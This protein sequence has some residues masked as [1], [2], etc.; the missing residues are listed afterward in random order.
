MAT[1]GVEIIYFLFFCKKDVS[2]TKYSIPLKGEF[3]KTG[4]EQ[5]CFRSI[6]LVVK[7]PRRMKMSMISLDCRPVVK[8]NN[9]N[10]ITGSQALFILAVASYFTN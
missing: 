9:P 2:S 8:E 10:H 3:L 1:W 4:S 6:C 7:S 5:N